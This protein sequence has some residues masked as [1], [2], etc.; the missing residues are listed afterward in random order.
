MNSPSFYRTSSEDLTIENLPDGS[1]AVFGAATE[2]VHSLNAPAA[3]AFEACKERTTLPELARAMT[4]ALASRVNEELA[5]AAMAELERAG[6]VAA[7]CVR[8][9]T[10]HPAAGAC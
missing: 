5:L 8:P 2:S 6:L 4:T 1:T 10:S 9:K 7:D 3:A